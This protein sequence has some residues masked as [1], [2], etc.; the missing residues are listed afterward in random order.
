DTPELDLKELRV[1]DQALP[2]EPRP[3]H[4]D[5]RAAHLD[6]PVPVGILEPCVEA[7]DAAERRTAQALDLDPTAEALSER[8]VHTGEHYGLNP[9]EAQAVEHRLG[10]NDDG[11]HGHEQHPECDAEEPERAERPFHQKDSPIPKEIAMGMPK[12]SPGVNSS[13]EA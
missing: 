9:A 7:L 11:E 6:H 2:K 3:E 5:I 4:R 12:I 8:A 10:Q 1:H 13:A